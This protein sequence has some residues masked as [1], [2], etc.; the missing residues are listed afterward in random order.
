MMFLEADCKE[1]NLCS[2]TALLNS[3]VK[4]GDTFT[5]EGAYS[6]YAGNPAQYTD[7]SMK[8]HDVN[9]VSARS[10]LWTMWHLR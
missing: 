10:P 9:I 8:A 7:P 3:D 1:T 5:L 2:L 4:V 6:D